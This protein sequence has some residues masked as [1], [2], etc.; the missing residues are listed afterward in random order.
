MKNNKIFQYVVIG[1]FVFFIIVGAIL[2]STYRSADKTAT[3][4]NITL[5][6]T[7]PADTFNTFV[8]QY[9]NEVNLKYKVNYTAKTPASFD[10]DLVEAIAS[11]A[12]PDAIILPT[13]L[14]MRYSNKIYPIPYA[15]LP[16]LT[17]KQNFIQEGELYLNATG[18]LALP[19]SVDPLVMYWNRDIFNNASLTKAPLTWAEVANLVPKMTKKDQVQNILTSTVALGEFRNVTNAKDILSTLLIQTGGSIVKTNEDGTFQSTLEDD[20]GLKVSPASL[21]LQFYTN[22]SNPVRPEYSWNRSLTNSLDA[23]ANGDLAIY[24]GFASEYLTIKNKNPNLNFDVSFIPQIANA[25]IYNTFGN[26]LGFAIMK[27]SPNPAGVY[28]VLSTLTSAEAFPFWK[29]LL[30]IPSARRDILNQVDNSAV[31]TVFNKSAIMSKG[32]LDPNS[33]KTGEIFQNM[34][35]SYTTGRSSLDES[36]NTASDQLDSLLNSK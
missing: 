33:L 5:W 18:T 15:V 32:W 27:T 12:G 24:F 7:L 19:F 1:L 26:M 16:E 30:N 17:F 6:G 2:F 10:R 31:K 21:A 36:I 11:G 28:T 20:F 23:F 14:I 25:K 22:F 13:N 35:E 3:N 29:D 4:I 34:V 8:S 9:F